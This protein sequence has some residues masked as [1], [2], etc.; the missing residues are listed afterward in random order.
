MKRLAL[1]FCL[2]AI[3]PLTLAACGGG[4]GG[5]G[6]VG[7]SAWSPSGT[8]ITAKGGQPLSSSSNTQT[9]AAMVSSDTSVS[10]ELAPG[11]KLAF[12]G[13]NIQF[14]AGGD[15]K[16]YDAGNK[17]IATF[18]P[19][20]IQLFNYK[21]DD[22]KAR[23]SFEQTGMNF[24]IANKPVVPV[25]GKSSGLISSSVGLWLGKLDYSVF[26][27][28][29]QFLE[30]NGG[31]IDGER[32]YGKALQHVLAGHTGLKADYSQV[33]ANAGSFTGIAAGVA[34]YSN[35][36]GGHWAGTQTVETSLL[37][38]ATLTLPSDVGSQNGKLVLTFPGFYEFA[39]SNVGVSDLIGGISGSF[40]SVT[41]K[42]SNFL[43]DGSPTNSSIVGQL[44]GASATAPSEAAGQWNLLWT[45][46][47]QGTGE[48]WHV[49]GAFGVKN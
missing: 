37:G 11:N 16:V 22:I 9:I 44:Y 32:L 40:N 5:G 33:V 21:P 14:E 38:T 6:G 48:T 35:T 25:P 43:P 8:S 17:L 36:Q 45:N 20:E 15:V 49:T 7:G 2:L 26:G 31:I 10:N 3:S 46:E 18:T 4:G 30:G 42:G 19:N 24:A 47:K 28:W 39:S 34:A 23:I 29:A 13:S 1:L 27:Y 41:S 12:G